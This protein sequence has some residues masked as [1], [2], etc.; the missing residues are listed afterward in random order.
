MVIPIQTV[1][2]ADDPMT[3]LSGTLELEIYVQF[4]KTNIH[5]EP[6]ALP[7]AVSGLQALEMSGLEIETIEGAFGISVCRINGVGCPASNCFCDIENFWTYHYWDHGQTQWVEHFFTP[8]S[9]LITQTGAI[10]G[11]HWGPSRTSPAALDTAQRIID[12]RPSMN[13]LRDQHMADGGFGT[14]D[15]TAETMLAVAASEINPFTWY[16]EMTG[17]KT[18]I[19]NTPTLLDYWSA[20]VDADDD[21]TNNAAAY[22]AEGATATGKL[23]LGV[24]G[25]SQNIYQFAG[26]NLVDRLKSY[27]DLE[28]GIFGSSNTDQIYGILGWHQTTSNIGSLLGVEPVP[29]VAVNVLRKRQNAD[30]GW[31]MMP[32]EDSDT[33]TTTLAIQALVAGDIC[34]GARDMKEAMAYLK[35][36]QRSDGG[37]ALRTN[38]TESDVYATALSIQTLFALGHDP[39]DEVWQINGKTP[40]DFLMGAQLAHGGFTSPAD[41]QADLTTTQA[42]LFTV[43]EETRL[44]DVPR[45][46]CDDWF[47]PIIGNAERVRN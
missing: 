33:P 5:I 26:I 19:E 32:E 41:T 38:R 43:V 30:G 44:L 45:P 34:N 31:G 29:D 10:E 16:D 13:W 14:H 24:A 7:E 18:P 37:F 42:A 3:R 39:S 4:D 23:L 36:V 22:V 12:T 20:D 6:V 40:W 25:I 28:N 1:Y 35:Q 9:T 27:Y 47:F 46:L 11:F 2:A 17:T 21:H 8:D 15:A